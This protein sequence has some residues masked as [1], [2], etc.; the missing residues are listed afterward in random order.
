MS[1]KDLIFDDFNDLRVKAEGKKSDAKIQVSLLKE[2]TGISRVVKGV[3]GA[4]RHSIMNL[5]HK[6]DIGYCSPTLKERFQGSDEPTLLDGEHLMGDC[7]E[8]PCPVRQLFGIFGEES[9][10]RVWSNVLVQTDKSPEKIIQQDGVSFVHVSM[11][12][13]H[14]AR[15]DKKSLQA[16]SE[17]YFSGE[18]QFNVEFSKELP[19]WLLGLLIK[20]ILG[21]TQLGRGGNS[22]YGRLE[23]KTI[24]F[25]KV[26][27]EKKLGVENNG[28]IVIVKNEQT[29]NQNH[30]LQE[31]LDAW[32]K[33]SN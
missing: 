5:L 22:G 9:A 30:L 27:H 14:Q 8:S 1:G 32:S 19:H 4:L 7:R 26:S 33:F 13:R 2:E 31:C 21:L 16:F 23:V 6:H 15:R 17:Q 29:E 3:R 11:E 28:S 25:E 20:G 18:F 24:S 10:I 12:N